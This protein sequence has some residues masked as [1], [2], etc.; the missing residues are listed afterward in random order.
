MFRDSLPHGSTN[1]DIASSQVMVNACLELKW[2]S[3]NAALPGK[4]WAVDCIYLGGNCLCYNQITLY[5]L[6]PKINDF[7]NKEFRHSWNEITSQNLSVEM[8]FPV[9]RIFVDDAWLRPHELFRRLLPWHEVC[10]VS[11]TR[12]P[13]S[14]RWHATQAR[15]LYSRQ[16]VTRFT[17][18]FGGGQYEFDIFPALLAF[19]KH[20]MFHRTYLRI[21]N[22]RRCM[23]KCL[24]RLNMWQASKRAEE[25]PGKFQKDWL[26][27]T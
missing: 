11:G 7:R 27:W 5:V 9:L 6:I 26:N 13:S 10:R 20:S 15:T 19:N 14:L 2:D 8:L 17:K 1:F 12:S 24:K 25:K 23:F 4:T 21:V 22:S 16:L 3:S 18:G